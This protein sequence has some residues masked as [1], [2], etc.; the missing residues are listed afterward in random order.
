MFVQGPRALS[1]VLGGGFVYVAGLRAALQ[2]PVHLLRP[3]HS[4]PRSL[5]HSYLYTTILT[6]PSSF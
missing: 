4:P 2:V 6:L 1:D 3:A 5:P